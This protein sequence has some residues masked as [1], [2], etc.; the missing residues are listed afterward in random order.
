MRLTYGMTNCPTDCVV[1]V[2]DDD[3]RVLESLEN[4]LQSAGHTVRVFESATT[5]LE[6]GTLAEID[7]L[8]SDIDLPTIDGF[9]LMRRAYAARAKLPVI[10]VT[11]HADMLKRGASTSGCHYRLFTKPFDG[12]ELL[13]AV[14][15][16]VRDSQRPI[17]GSC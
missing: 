12:Q 4:L 7:C 3:R 8:I 11:G 13:R 1:A 2:V 16:A 9:E 5:L 10:L 14:S 17:P 6:S 15:D